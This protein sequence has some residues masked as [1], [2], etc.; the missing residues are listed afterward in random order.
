[1]KFRVSLI[2]MDK[3]KNNERLER[4]GSCEGHSS[5]KI[6]TCKL[7][8]QGYDQHP[9][10]VLLYKNELITNCDCMLSILKAF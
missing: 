7:F 6:Y 1:M 10:V 9:A 2:T 4:L 8:L 5:S 3:T